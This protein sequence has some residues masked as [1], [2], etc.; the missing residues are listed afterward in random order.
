[1][2]RLYTVDENP[3]RPYVWCIL[4][5]W[6][7]NDSIGC[8]LKEF[9]LDARDTI[10]SKVL[11]VHKDG[12]KVVPATKEPR[13]ISSPSV[14]SDPDD[15]GLPNEQEQGT[16]EETTVSKD[17]SPDDPITFINVVHTP[18]KRRYR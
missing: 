14:P 5:D 1:M 7:H 13:P 11:G 18:S 4:N 17:Y 2:I 8:R 10:N 9:T 16:V 12:V 3:I 6:F 15:T